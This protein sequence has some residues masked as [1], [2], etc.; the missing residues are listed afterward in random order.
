[1][2]KKKK[3][4]GGRQSVPQKWFEEK[5]FKEGGG[6]DFNGQV[7]KIR[8]ESGN[9]DVMDSIRIPAFWL[10]TTVWWDLLNL[11]SAACI[12]HLDPYNPDC[13]NEFQTTFLN[14]IGYFHLNLNTFHL[15]NCPF[16]FHLN[17]F[18]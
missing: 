12:W 3:G 2:W 15:I 4:G 5:K 11:S 14:F 7:D 10:L 18:T 9:V 17:Y 6:N 16:Y 1:M 13:F 8:S